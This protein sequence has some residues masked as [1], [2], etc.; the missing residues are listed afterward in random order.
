MSSES[1]ASERPRPEGNR[2]NPDWNAWV[3]LLAIPIVLPLLT[4]LYNRV[5][6]DLFGIPAFYWVQLAFVPMSAG[7]TAIV[8]FKT[9]KR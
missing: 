4:P 8:Y 6:P 2:W 5:E 9:R 3:Y 1:K 7:I